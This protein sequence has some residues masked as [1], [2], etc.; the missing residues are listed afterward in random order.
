MGPLLS[1]RAVRPGNMSLR[2]SGDEAEG[3]VPGEGCCLGLFPT[4]GV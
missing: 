4:G 2:V 3:W 1:D